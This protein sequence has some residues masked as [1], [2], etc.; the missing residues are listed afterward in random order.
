MK[1]KYALTAVFISIFAD[2][3][4]AYYSSDLEAIKHILDTSD[5]TY[6]SERYKLIGVQK[7]VESCYSAYRDTQS[8]SLIRQCAV[9]DLTGYKLAAVMQSLGLQTPNWYFHRLTFENRFLPIMEK[10]YSGEE[11]YKIITE[12]D[13][14]VEEAMGARSRA[15]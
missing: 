13:F 7:V 10:H 3:A 15:R 11:I 6:P 14:L 1:I 9:Y 2:S 8:E 4:M 12:T 5:A